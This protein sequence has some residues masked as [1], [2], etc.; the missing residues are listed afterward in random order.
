[1]AYTQADL[2]ALD[3][4]I[5]SSTLE[6]QLGERR[7]KYRSMAELLQAR[8]HVASQIAAVTGRGSFKPFTFTTLRG[9]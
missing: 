3:R 1:M 9:F 6:V 8:Q 7:V 4:A 5:A 2:D